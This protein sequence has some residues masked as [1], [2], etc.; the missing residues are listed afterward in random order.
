MRRKLAITSGYTIPLTVPSRTVS[1][2]VLCCVAEVVSRGW[3][4]A[5]SG[6][7]ITYLCPLPP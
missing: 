1:Q 3:Y 5:D 6:V 2:T 7:R 4:T